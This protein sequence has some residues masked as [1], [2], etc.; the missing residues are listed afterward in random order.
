[1]AA[2]CMQ[3]RCLCAVS[4]AGTCMTCLGEAGL[5]GEPWMGK[6]K[7]DVFLFKVSCIHV[8]LFVLGQG[9]WLQCLWAGLG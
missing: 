6:H 8:V 2:V 9:S 3:P 1:M 4:M 7:H 5:N